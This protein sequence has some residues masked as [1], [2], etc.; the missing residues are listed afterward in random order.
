MK[1]F[2]FQVSVTDN[3]KRLDAFLAEKKPFLTRTQVQKTIR[4]KRVWV[5]S[6]VQ[7]ASYR[8]RSQELILV[9]II[10]PVPT[11]TQPENIPL[12]IIFEDSWIIVVNKPAG[13]VVHPGCGNNSGTLVNA[14]L[15]HC[16]TLSGIGGVLRP[17]IVHRLDKGTSGILVI[18]KNDK[19]H[20]ELSKQFKDHTI[21]RKYQALVYGRIEK[22]SD[23]IK[24]LI[25][26]H[27]L[28]RK[29][30]SAMPRKGREAVTHW[31]VK[32]RFAGMSLLEVT[33]ETGRTHQVRVHLSSIGHP[34]VGDHVYG[35]VKRVKDF[36][37]KLIRD[38]VKGIK[39]PLLHAGYLRFLHPA[40]LESMDFT[41]P[42]PEDFGNLLHALRSKQ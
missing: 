28:H 38:L 25:G 1:K 12:E 3:G 39:R 8:L 10:D 2:Q 33:L 40:A 5:D 34:V 26:R 17:G 7:K 27:P 19:A 32:D 36:D 22:K 9:E 11:R 6:I 13:M 4:D 37:L 21:V 23:S 20:Q 14:L 30:M 24:T 35:S 15:Y 42:L 31:E 18:A 41:V 29:K 16:T